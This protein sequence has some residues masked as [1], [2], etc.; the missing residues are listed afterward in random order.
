MH[1]TELYE[2]GC[3]AYD[4]DR[5]AR[6]LWLAKV[7]RLAAPIATRYGV[8]PGLFAAKAAL[9]SGYASD[10][11]EV[12]FYEPQY[13]VKM[14][15]KAQGHNNIIAMNAFEDNMGYLPTFPKPR[16]ASEKLCFTDYAPHFYRDRIEI[17]PSE[18][19]KHFD[20]VEDCCEDWCANMRWQAKKH[21][22]A[23]GETI[24]RQLLAIE[25]YTPEGEAAETPG[26]HY[27]WQDYVLYLY[28]DYDLYSYDTEAYG[29]TVPMTQE[30]L[31]ENIKRAYAYAHMHCHYAPCVTYPPMEDGCADCSGLAF[32][33]LYTMGRMENQHFNID[34]IHRLCEKAGLKKSTDINDVWRHHGV[35][36]MQD[37]NNVGTSHINHVFYSLSG[38]SVNCISKYDLG[39]D[40]RIQSVQPFRNVPVNEWVDRR[41]FLCVYCIPDEPGNKREDTPAFDVETK[42][43][44]K[45]TKAAGIYAGTGTAWRRK[46][47]VN[48]GDEALSCGLVTNDKGNQ[49]RYVK[50]IPSGL[51]GYVAASAVQ[52]VTF[53]PYKG[54]VSGTP[55]GFLALRIGAGTD[56]YKV[57]EIPEGDSL[58]VDGTAEGGAWLHVKWKGKRGFVSATHV[59]KV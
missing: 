40:E 29:M 26:M 33:A 36:C 45:I 43:Y 17:A 10:L 49:W 8:L 51:A 25:S 27:A 28:R 48:P 47:T 50:L 7:A 16:W 14:A 41:N 44:A 55:D 39:S 46:G 59:K 31:D 12:H 9:E 3:R 54:T 20:S 38:T 23:W 30:N 53:S 11:Y 1:A 21:G 52:A 15:R 4:G 37:K 18:P 13:H 57:A 35:V 42:H 24:E 56:C 34:D 58:R 19:W 6:R 22:R 2:L 5:G 32:R